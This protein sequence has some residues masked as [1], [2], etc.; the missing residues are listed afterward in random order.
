M[1]AAK[2]F[3]FTESPIEIG[4]QWC[5]PVSFGPRKRILKPRT[6]QPP[7]PLACT[8]VTDVGVPGPVLACVG[9]TP[10]FQLRPRPKALR[11]QPASTCAGE[12][13]LG[14]TRETSS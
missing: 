5:D 13:D 8:Q 10:R 1:Q 9:P 3:R 11:W 14:Q 7:P 6:S 12:I 4:V 2:A